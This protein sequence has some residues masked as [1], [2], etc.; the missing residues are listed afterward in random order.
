MIIPEK[1]KEIYHHPEYLCDY[2]GYQVYCE[3]Y[4]KDYPSIGMPEFVLYKDNTARYASK[5]EISAIMDLLPD[6]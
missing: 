1:V 6:D 4:G 5:K 2:Q 3:N